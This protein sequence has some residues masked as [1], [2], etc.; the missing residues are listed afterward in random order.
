MK[1]LADGNTTYGWG[2]IL[3]KLTNVVTGGAV[4]KIKKRKRDNAAAGQNQTSSL[5]K[6]TPTTLRG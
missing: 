3:R 5:K 1:H 6:H 2:A 4:N